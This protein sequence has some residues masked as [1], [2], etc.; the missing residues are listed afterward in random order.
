MKNLLI[1]SL[2]SAFVFF[3]WGFI[4]FGASG[5]PYNFLG[6]A[7]DPGAVLDASFPTDGTYVVPDPRAENAAE[8]MERGPFAVVHIKKGGSAPMDPAMMVGGFLHGFIYAALLGLLLQA[9]KPAS[10]GAS[11]K[12]CAIAGLAGAF[13][14]RIGDVIWWHKSWAW[15]LSDLAYATIGSLLIG[16]VL[17]KFIKSPVKN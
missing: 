10:Y 9:A 12:F 7:G 15:Q 14:A 17:A 11:V 2:L 4:Y 13:M 8:L 16:L 1:G 3:I 5:I 6:D